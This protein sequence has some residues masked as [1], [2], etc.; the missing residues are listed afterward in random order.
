M[1]QPTESIFI[2]AILMLQQEL[3]PVH[4]E[5]EL[6]GAPDVS[7][8]NLLQCF[9]YLPEFD[10]FLKEYLLKYE[11]CGS[12]KTNYLSHQIYDEISTLMAKDLK[13]SDKAKQARYFAIT[14]DSTPDLSRV[15]QLTFTIRHI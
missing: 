10:E 15:D 4:P 11:A 5:G 2:F 3:S 8:R 13:Q 9:E 14:M 12:G 7:T 6:Q 1:V